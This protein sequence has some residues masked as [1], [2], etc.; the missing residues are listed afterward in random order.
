MQQTVSSAMSVVTANKKIILLSLFVTLC[1]VSIVLLVKALQTSRTLATPDNI[2][3]TKSRQI[4]LLTN[5]WTGVTQS[6]KGIDSAMEPLQGE[7]SNQ[8]LLINTAVQSVRLGGYAGPYSD[9]VFDEDGAT[10]LALSSGARCLILEIDRESDAPTKPVLVYRDGWGMKRSLNTGD[11]EKVARSIAGRAF[12]T[13]TDSAPPGV[14]SDPLFVV[15][16]FR[17]AP[18]AATSVKDYIRFLAATAQALAP[19]KPLLLG[20]TSAGDFRR[21]QKES[22]L[23]FLPFETFKNRIILLTNAD[24]T[25]FRQL[26]AL[27]LD[28]EITSDQNLDDMIHARL[29]SLES[30]SGL[31]ISTG[32]T[33]AQTPRAVITTANYWLMMPSDRIAEAQTKTKSVWTLVMPPTA[34]ETSSQEVSQKLGTLMTQYG[35]HSVPFVLFDSTQ[36]TDAFVGVNAPFQSSAWVVKPELLRF[37]PPKLIVTQKPIPQTNSGGG[38]LVAPQ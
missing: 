3:A 24:T 33:T 2:E 16:Y 7:K 38:A 5:R 28:T 30:P 21:Q 36:I 25:V 19:L 34:T 20:Q 22:E 10:R 27:G 12:R 4:T 23:F 29:Y 11:L 26:S 37:I 31:G 1:I 32:P 18:N 35:V 9:G 8:R 15:I 13:S 17:S 6:K 14:V